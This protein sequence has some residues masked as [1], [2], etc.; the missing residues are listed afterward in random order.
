MAFGTDDGNLHLWDARTR[1]AARTWRGH[2]AAVK[3]VDLRPGAEGEQLLSAGADGRVPVSEV[4]TV[5]GE[6]TV[7]SF[8][9]EGR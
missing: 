7:H 2:E 4:R 9:L 6:I 8:A 5:E 3:A 1:G